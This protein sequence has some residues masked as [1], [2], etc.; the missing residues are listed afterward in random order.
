MGR[1]IRSKGEM[2]VHLNCIEHLQDTNRV[3]SD[4]IKINSHYPVCPSAD[5]HACDGR[6]HLD[7]YAVLLDGIDVPFVPIVDLPATCDHDVHGIFYLDRHLLRGLTRHR[8]RHSLIDDFIS[9]A[10]WPLL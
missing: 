4:W 9:R 2:C 3:I 1:K 10:W 5:C 8:S 6:L 7:Y